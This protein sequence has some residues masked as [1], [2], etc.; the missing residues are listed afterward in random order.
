M[1]V[2]QEAVMGGLLEGQQTMAAILHARLASVR[3]V[4]S[5]WAKND[6][7]GALQAAH[8]INDIPVRM[9]SC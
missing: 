4:R 3:V 7:K 6:V 1:E 8:R 5:F 2:E 9:T